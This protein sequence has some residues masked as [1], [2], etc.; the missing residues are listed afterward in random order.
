M[1]SCQYIIDQKI[2]NVEQNIKNDLN[3]LNNL[4]NL[5]NLINLINF[6]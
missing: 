4:N 2:F 3:Y 5:N 6:S 1:I